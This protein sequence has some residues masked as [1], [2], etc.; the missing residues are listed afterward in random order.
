MIR[1]D[2]QRRLPWKRRK[3]SKLH[4][5]LIRE[6]PTSW[7]DSEWVQAECGK[8]NERLTSTSL[9]TPTNLSRTV[10]HSASAAMNTIDQV[11]PVRESK[12][13]KSFGMT[14]SSGRRGGG[15]D[16]GFFD[17]FCSAVRENSF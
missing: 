12:A 9:L 14:S 15:D 7:T 10:S 4:E 2:S 16:G 13:S 11:A 5:T 17:R 8:L 3:E 6:K 1:V